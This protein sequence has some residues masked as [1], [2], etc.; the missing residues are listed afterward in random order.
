[1]ME[2]ERGLLSENRGDSKES[3]GARVQAQTNIG[4]SRM[5]ET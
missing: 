1:M 3:K 4:R 2:E 5:H